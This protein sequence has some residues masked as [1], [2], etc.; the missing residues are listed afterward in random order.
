MWLT[1]LKIAIIEKNTDAL[2]LLLDDMPK[3]SSVEE[4]KEAQYLLAEASK[5]LHALKDE[6]GSS[7]R[8]VQKNI[9]FLQSTQAQPSNKLDIKS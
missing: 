6:I 8:Q 4:M 2:N 7:M 3:L 9:S 1:K 5:L